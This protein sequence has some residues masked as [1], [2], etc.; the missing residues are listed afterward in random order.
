[1]FDINNFV[2]DRVIRGVMTSTA[3][4]SVMYS[5]NQI[6]DP[7]LTV[8][9]DE[10]TAV[11]ALGTTIATFQNAKNA[12]FSGSNSLFDLSLLAAQQGATK[13][14]GTTTAKLQAPMFETIDVAGTTC[15]LKYAPVADP[16][17]IYVLNGDSTLGTKFVKDTVASATAF[18]YN[19]ATRTITLP[20]TVVNGSQVFI[21]YDY[22]SSNVVS[23]TASATEFAKAG[24]FVMEVL[25]VDVC[26]PTTLIY[27]YIIFPNA[28]LDS[29]VDITFSTDGK[30]PFS[31][32]AQQAY[33]SK[34]KQL[35]QI[36]IPQLV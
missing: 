17:A 27:A 16:T 30:H 26:D 3:D 32:K 25:G 5:I 24:K 23:V 35:F 13:K 22:L 31:M 34:D 12:E 19:N 1:M 20:T 6:E 10:K 2:I 21:M 11:D 9:A 36:I 33:C 4:G 7:S 8:S 28:K 29:N 14:V 15:V 18:A